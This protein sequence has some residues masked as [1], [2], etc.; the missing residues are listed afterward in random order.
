MTRDKKYHALYEDKIFMGGAADV[1]DMV[2]N[3]GI[4][5]VV[6]LRAESVECSYPEASVEWVKI[7]LGDNAA[8]SQENLFRSAIDA[9]VGAYREGKKVAFHCGGGKGRTG[10]VAIGTLLELGEA[11]SID[12]AELK[13]KNIRS[14]ID[15]KPAQRESLEKLYS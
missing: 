7:P 10:T 4:D 14:M 13:A 1:K 2:L 3:E 8:G 11:S 9:V 15:V 12:E 6:D 5:V